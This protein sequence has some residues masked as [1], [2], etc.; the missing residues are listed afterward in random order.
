MEV[1]RLTAEDLFTVATI[2]GKCGQ[3]ATR[4]IS[5][6]TEKSD[7]AVG[8][9]IISVALAHAEN[10]IKDWLASLVDKTPEEF[11]KLPFSAP[12]EI[13]EKL[14]EQEDIP[15]FFGRAK[16]LTTFGKK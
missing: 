16:K 9:A 15:S 3:D 7:S 4:I 5:S 13:V 11:A 12:L 6:L 14:F 10:E 2:L 1:R 8:M